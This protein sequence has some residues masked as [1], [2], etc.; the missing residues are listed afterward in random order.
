MIRRRR[1]ALTLATCGLA[2]LLALSACSSSSTGGSGDPGYAQSADKL[3]LGIVPDQQGAATQW[4]PLVQ[5]LEQ[6]LDKDVELVESVDYAALIEASVA[7]HLDIGVI[8]AFSYVA[9]SNA[10][11]KF[12]PVA[13]VVEEE[14]GEPGYDSVAIVPKDSGIT[15]VAGFKGKK[16]CF[17][18]YGSTS[19]YLYP[20]ATLLDAGVDPEKDITPVMAGDHSLSAQKTAQGVECDAGFAQNSVVET[21]GVTDGLFKEGDLRIVNRTKIPGKPIVVSTTL[22][23][24]VQKAITDALVGVSVPKIA[25]TGIKTPDGFISQFWSAVATDDSYYDGV[26]EV[27]ELTKSAQCRP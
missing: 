10:G 25:K 26:R 5:Y 19:G 1:R 3:I 21:T 17:V 18:D 9:A 22:P 8:S 20:S 15:D 2:S 23:K 24:D 27:C 7:G 6:S 13:A 12:D 16:V 11:A 4:E 14:G